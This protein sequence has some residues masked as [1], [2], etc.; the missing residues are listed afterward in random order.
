MRTLLSYS[1][2]ACFSIHGSNHI[3]NGLCQIVVKLVITGW[4]LSY[5]TVTSGQL[6]FYYHQDLVE[7]LKT[8]LSRAKKGKPPLKGSDGKTKRNM[9]P[10]A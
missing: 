5:F 1:V 9:N 3:T 4:L 10:E 8:D 2:C 7:E 6:T